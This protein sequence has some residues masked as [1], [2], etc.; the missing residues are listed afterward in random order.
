MD[1]VRDLLDKA[2]V[3]LRAVVRESVSERRGQAPK[4]SLLLEDAPQRVPV[5]ADRERLRTMVGN[6]LENAIKRS[7]EGGEVRCSVTVSGWS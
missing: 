4:A 7:P 1:L 2:V 5:R 6:L 3:D